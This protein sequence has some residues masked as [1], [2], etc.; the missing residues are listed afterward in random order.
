MAK[1]PKTA[2]ELAKMIRV[3]VYESEL[4]MLTHG[5]GAGG[6][7]QCRLTHHY[8]MLLKNEAHFM[9]LAIG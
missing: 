1:I 6:W 9:E 2:K 4:L 7:P 5:R 3:R 8:N